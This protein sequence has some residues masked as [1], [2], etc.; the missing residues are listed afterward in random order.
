MAY[1]NVRER[2]LETKIAYVGPAQ[3]GK[4]TNFEHLGGGAMQDDV[5]ALFWQPKSEV[6]FRDCDV[7]VQLVAARGE[8]SS[9]RVKTL[10]RDVDGVVFVADATPSAQG[11]NREILAAIRAAL[12]ASPTR[13]V[14][15]VVQVNKS[16]RSD[17]LSAADVVGGLDVADLPLVSAAALRGEGVVE[18]AERALAAVLETLRTRAPTESMATAT[19][20]TTPREGNP[21]LSALRDILRE[22]VATH[23]A[24][25]ESRLEAKLDRVLAASGTL[26]AKLL[27]QREAVASL[28][29]AIRATNAEVA[30]W[31][32]SNA[33]LVRE[34]TTAIG[35]TRRAVDVLL[36]EMK[37]TRPAV[38]GLKGDL[39]AILRESALI[40]PRIVEAEGLLGRQLRDSMGGLDHRV[41]AV[42]VAA[43]EG[44]AEIATKAEI[45]GLFEALIEEL[46][47]PKKG[48][49]G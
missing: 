4:G 18:T 16:D 12:E 2:R 26:T 3:S 19:A 39:D 21:L 34:Q 33:K 1:L 5:L 45:Q 32:E 6:T 11:K 29:A 25:M 7:R 22:T 41:Q 20:T 35:T 42:G 10:L 36:G 24:E 37:D 14:P 31:G 48:W 49:F 40:R 15:V 30:K 38:L 27:E 17:A 43:N 46:K 28:D 23:V 47:K 8:T 13:G 44:R 9:E